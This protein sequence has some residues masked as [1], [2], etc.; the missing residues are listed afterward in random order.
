[1]GKAKG[2]LR[3]LPSKTTSCSE[4]AEGHKKL[5]KVKKEHETA[6]ELQ[7]KI[8]DWIWG[9]TVDGK[10]PA[11]LGDKKGAILHPS[12]YKKRLQDFFHQP[13]VLG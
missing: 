13:Y 11:F 1:M 9:D 4:L 2:G 6:D 7:S 10:N 8:Q 3:T 5:L 12:V